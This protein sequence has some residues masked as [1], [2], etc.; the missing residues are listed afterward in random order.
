ML[1]LYQIIAVFCDI[2]ENSKLEIIGLIFTNGSLI[3]FYKEHLVLFLSLFLQFKIFESSKYKEYMLIYHR[4][5]QDEFEEILEG[6]HKIKKK[7]DIFTR[8]YIE[9]GLWLCYL[10][11]LIIGLFPPANLSSLVYLLFLTLFVVLTLIS[12]D[13]QKVNKILI[14]L[15]YK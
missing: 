11:M 14:I 1:Y 15:T 9:Y 4:M 10:C 2:K 6:H 5:D 7:V 3:A 8:F 13:E 12:N